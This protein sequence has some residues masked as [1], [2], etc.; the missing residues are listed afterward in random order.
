[1]ALWSWPSGAP[2]DERRAL[3][4]FTISPNWKGG[5]L[6]TL[7]WLTDVMS[8]E[9]A[10]EQRRGVRRWPR[11]MFE[12]GFLRQNAYRARLDNFL[13]GTGREVFLVPLWHE[14]FTLGSGRTDGIVVFP[15]G[16]LSTREFRQGDLVL[17]T[18]G[19]PDVFAIL[20]VAAINT[21]VD[22]IMLV[23]DGKAGFW[24]KGSR[25]T[26]L[27]RAI[28][29][30]QMTMTAPA[31]R[32]G[33]SQIRFQLT[34]AD[35]NFKASWG[36][37]SP[38]W[39]FKPDRKEPIEFT[40]DRSAYMHDMDGGVVHITDPGGRAQITQSM[41][42]KL[43]GREAVQG[44]RA[45]LYAARGRATRFYVPTFTADLHPTADLGGLSFETRLN[46]MNEYMRLPQ[47]SR[48]LI[49]IVFTD[50]RPTI[51]RKIKTIA[52]VLDAN[53]QVGERYTVTLAVPPIRKQ[54]IDRIMFIVPSR[55]D[56]DSIDIL[57]VTDN[58]A[59]ISSA[60]VTRSSILD[61]MPS[62]DCFVTSKPYPVLAV[63]TLGVSASIVAGALFDSGV[64]ALDNIRPSARF[65]E[66]SLRVM[67]SGIQPGPDSFR[68]T[69]TVSAGTLR[70]V[71]LSY[72]NYAPENFTVS[73]AIVAGTIRKMLITN[74]IPPESVT[75]TASISTGTLS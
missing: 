25:I 63:E 65:S 16:T 74:S 21:S 7:S 72:N 70:R 8:S 47:D 11:R 27:R 43:F 56:M 33:Q 69:A 71:L 23:G 36:Y 22:Q 20:T 6:E 29:T 18:N 46:G 59:A 53:R 58:A 51:Y 35:S 31:D 40:Y 9:Q 4:V 32:V 54:D 49:G 19:D 45:F 1:M 64:K 67:L 34:D 14:Q 13:V 41:K 48:V 50:G 39:R 26:P 55:L 10:V 3:R 73:A 15:V 30:D 28:I 75:V 42:V 38:L 61:G 57:H 37:C 17:V 5:I 44:Y 68:T 24:P 62:L 66:G 60:V 2:V 12:A 52:P